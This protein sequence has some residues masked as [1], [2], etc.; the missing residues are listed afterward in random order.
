MNA[1]CRPNDHMFC[2]WTSSYIHKFH[3]RDVGDVK[4]PGG[5]SSKGTYSQLTVSEGNSEIA[6]CHWTV[7]GF[8]NISTDISPMKMTELPCI[9]LFKR[10]S[11][12]EI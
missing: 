10:N 11:D 9:K 2:G 3:L 4:S 8:A 6:Q 7:D 5:A 1:K 12:G